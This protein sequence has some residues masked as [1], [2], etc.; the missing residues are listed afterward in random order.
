MFQ[1]WLAMSE[2]GPL[3]GTLLVNPLVRETGVYALLRPFFRP[4]KGLGEVGGDRARYLEEG[5]WEFTG[6]EKMGSEIQGA[7]PGCAQEFPEG[8]HPHLEL[9][10]TMVHVPEVRPGDYV[11]WHC[12]CECSPPH[13]MWRARR[14]ILTS[15]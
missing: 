1:G 3:R 5:N 11:V 14:M 2:S 6:G 13:V 4:R 15:V 10:R 9:D 7:M 12:D 8:A